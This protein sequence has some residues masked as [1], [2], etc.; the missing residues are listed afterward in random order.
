MEN[1]RSRDE[2]AN[3]HALELESLYNR[4]DTPKS[5]KYASYIYEKLS[6]YGRDFILPLGWLA[7]LFGVFLLIY[8]TLIRATAI[9]PVVPEGILKFSLGFTLDQLVLPFRG[10]LEKLPKA[11]EHIWDYRLLYRF[12]GAVQSIGSISLIALFLLAL[13]RRF[14]MD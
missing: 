5:V 14:K 3:F 8:M 7:T 9:Q 11:V 1:L 12:I 4:D 13:R 10:G 6:D 2:E